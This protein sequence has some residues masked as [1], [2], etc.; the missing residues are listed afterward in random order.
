MPSPLLFSSLWVL[1]W[2]YKVVNYF[3]GSCSFNLAGIIDNLLDASFSAE[4]CDAIHLA[5]IPSWAIFTF[6]TL[7]TD[8]NFL[9]FFKRGR[10][11]NRELQSLG[12]LCNFLNFC[13]ETLILHV[14]LLHECI[15]EEFLLFRGPVGILSFE[16]WW[17]GTSSWWLIP[18]IDW[19]PIV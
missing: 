11:E 13:S 12:L 5:S 7:R 2:Y 19:I 1:R 10:A 3:F 4:V 18:S 8:N 17:R 9:A 16:V 14:L 6:E 15:F